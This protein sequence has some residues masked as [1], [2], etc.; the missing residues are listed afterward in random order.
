MK[1]SGCTWQQLYLLHL[2]NNNAKY[3]AGVSQ[4]SLAHLMK[5]STSLTGTLRV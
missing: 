2:H 3:V 4:A 1:S 5:A